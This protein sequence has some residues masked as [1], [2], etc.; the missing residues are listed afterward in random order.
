MLFITSMW[1]IHFNT[2][3]VL[4]PLLDGAPCSWAVQDRLGRQEARYHSNRDRWIDGQHK[5]WP[6]LLDTIPTL[7]CKCLPV[8]STTPPANSHTVDW[9]LDLMSYTSRPSSFLP[10]N[11]SLSCP[12]H[13][14]MRGLL[15]LSGANPP[16]NQQGAACRSKLVFPVNQWAHSWVLPIAGMLCM[17]YFFLML[18]LNLTCRIANMGTGRLIPLQQ[19]YCSRSRSIRMLQAITLFFLRFLVWRGWWFFFF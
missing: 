13:E 5:K 4:C 16:A 6:P 2:F 15:T 9:D 14:P 11:H 10:A 8:W 19:K 17:M 12:F 18:K 3:S 1:N 7:F